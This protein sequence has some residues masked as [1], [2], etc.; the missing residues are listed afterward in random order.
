MGSRKDNQRTH[1]WTVEEEQYLVRWKGYSPVHDSW[2]NA[3]ELHAPELLT[4]F[5]VAHSIKT[6]L[7]DDISVGNSLLYW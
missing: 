6:L 7:L 2:V 5:Q 3:E 4:D 1:L